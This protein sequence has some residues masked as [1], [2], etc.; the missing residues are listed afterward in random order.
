MTRLLVVAPNW[1]GDAVMAL[2]AVADVRRASPD[3]RITVV[4]P[5][6][7]A[8]LFRMV[9][10]V[11]EVEEAKT[12][13]G[14]VFDSVLLLP[15]SFR[16][17]FDA[18]RAGIPERWGYRT[19]GRRWLLT[20]SV[21]PPPADMHQVDCYQ[22]LVRALGFPSGPREPRLDV[23]PTLRAAGGRVLADAGWDGAAPFV[24]LAPGAAFGGAKRWP[25][26][27]F[28]ALARGL[29]SDGVR[30]VLIGSAADQP[31][32]R[33]VLSSLGADRSS[34]FDA[35]GRTDVQTLAGLITHARA[36]VANDSGAMHLAA[37]I[38]V[39]LAA[40]FGP[41]DERKTAPRSTAP[42]AVLTHAVWCRPCMLRECP[43]DHACMRGVPVADV[44]DATRRLC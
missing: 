19:D 6:A 34:V 8:S 4:G 10:D 2:P 17:A 25:P 31:V 40:V 12:L 26:D 16:S 42:S 24:A 13:S 21:P 5:P 20:R 7:V 30:S 37:A 36:V 29:A 18:V 9:G 1:L 15:N 22:Q 32:A 33:Q 23:A 14:R 44:F 35:V 38:G 43:L 11:D 28:A 3:A 39:P 27:Y 41:T